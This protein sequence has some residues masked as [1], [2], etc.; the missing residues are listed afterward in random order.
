MR[1]LRIEAA[2][3]THEQRCK[4][5]HPSVSFDFLRLSHLHGP[6]LKERIEDLVYMLFVFSQR[7]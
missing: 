7:V 1:L 4:A 3:D 6:R 5:Q 2:A